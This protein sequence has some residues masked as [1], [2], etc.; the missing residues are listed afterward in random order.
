MKELYEYDEE[1]RDTIATVDAQGKRIWVFPKKP[2]GKFY[3]ARTLVSIILLSIL[4]A[5]PFIKI[6]GQ[7]F[8]LLNIFERKFMV[9]GTVFWPQ[10]FFIF[11]LGLITFFVFIILFTVV[12]GRVW[13]GWACPQTLFM[14]MVFRRIEYWIEGDANQQRKLKKSPWNAEKIGKR[15]LKHSIFGLIAIL[16]G[17]T[18]M[19]YL[20]GIEKVK[21][22]VTQSPA[23]NMAG[24][25]G[26]V[27]FS[28]IFYGVFAYLRE[29]ACIAICPYGRLQG[30]LLVK[31]SMAVMYDWIRGEPRGKMKKD[32][33]QADK[34]DCIDCKLCV[35]VCPTGIDIRNGTQLECVNCTACIDV[36]DDV[37]TKIDRPKGLI[38]VSSYNAIAE[39]KK[40]LFTPRV[41]GYT[42]VLVVLITLLTV[43]VSTRSD[44]QATI[45]RV[46]GMLYQRVEGDKIQNLYNIQ[47][48]NKTTEE[49]TINIK[50]MDSVGS[51]EVVGGHT[52][53]IAPSGKSDAVFYV[54]FPEN[55]LKGNKNEIVLGIYQ[56]EV[57]IDEVKSNFLGPIKID[58]L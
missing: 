22:I 45:L 5:G 16:I 14:E 12:F 11:A 29:Q 2:K 10:D 13:C 1:Y 53:T 18:A 51:I 20:I 37:M 40:K 48:I 8:L 30:V 57:L 25:L 17:H 23:E 33:V 50:L 38:K 34:G 44:I 39:G 32:Q 9:L 55:A 56:G 24:F 46:P 26:L 54:R 6:G 52:I 3:N 35:H 43:F 41:A 7:P 31:D 15:L 21:E 4:F 42:G 49:M 28:F 58:S 36:C 19:A 27:A 47:L